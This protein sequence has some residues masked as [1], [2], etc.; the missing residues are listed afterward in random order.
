MVE[1][2]IKPIGYEEGRSYNIT[3]VVPHGWASE[4]FD[5]L[6]GHGHASIGTYHKDVTHI[7]LNDTDPEFEKHLVYI[8]VEC[9]IKEDDLVA[10]I[11]LEIQILQNKRNVIVEKISKRRDG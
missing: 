9:A 6:A 4:K 11:D 3:A 1:I 7:S 5:F 2:Y 8:I 10:K